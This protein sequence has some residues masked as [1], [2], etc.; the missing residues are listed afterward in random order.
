MLCNNNCIEKQE[1]M[2]TTI[3]WNKFSMKPVK[4]LG[5]FI[6]IFSLIA[7]EC[8]FYFCFSHWTMYQYSFW[9]E[10]DRQ[11]EL[12]W[13]VFDASEKKKKICLQVEQHG[14]LHWWAWW[15]IKPLTLKETVKHLHAVNEL[16][17]WTSGVN[18]HSAQWGMMLKPALYAC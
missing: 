4:A 8:L 11:K 9:P 10:V 12:N 15:W 1:N 17:F 14:R 18:I 5:F 6:F 16:K 7:V 13:K 2:T 3:A